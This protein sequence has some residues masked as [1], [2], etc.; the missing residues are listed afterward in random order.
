MIDAIHER[1][2]VINDVLATD[3]A[4][5]DPAVTAGMRLFLVLL[6][7]QLPDWTGDV[8]PICQNIYDLVCMLKRTAASDPDP[9]TR[10][11][12]ALLS[13][14]YPC[15]ELAVLSDGWHEDSW[16]ELYGVEGEFFISANRMY[17]FDHHHV[18]TIVQTALLVS[19]YRL[20]PLLLSSLTVG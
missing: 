13:M 14:T 15:E 17:S 18:S 19:L 10:S 1:L 5:R 7:P 16:E 12:C 11:N 3:A 8:R 6:L 20:S 9:L 4:M 2:G